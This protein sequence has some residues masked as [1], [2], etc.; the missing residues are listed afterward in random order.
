[1]ASK[2]NVSKSSNIQQAAA[3]RARADSMSAKERK[4]LATK[5]AHARWKRD[6]DGISVAT[7]EGS[8]QLPGFDLPCAVLKDGRRIFSER[9]LA[10]AFTHVR[11]GS[12]FK[13]RRQQPD[14]EQLPVFMSETV[15]SYL[16]E[17]ARERLATPIRYR[18]AGGGI[19]ARGVDAELLADLCDAYL[20]A[21]EDGALTSPV[22][23]RKAAAAERLTR[24][25]AKVG[26]TALID[27]ATGYQL[28]RDK[29]EL[30][31]L[32]DVY[33]REE[34]RP[35][36]AMFPTEF[37]RQ[38]F[39]LRGLTT[40]DVRKRPAYFGHLTNGVVYD[41]LLPGMVEKLNQV[42]P[43][44]EDGRR[45]RRHHQ[46]ATNEGVQHL[47]EHLSGVLFLMKASKNWDDFL[48]RLDMAAPKQGG[49][50]D[51]VDG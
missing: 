4:S 26:V 50:D 7:H 17:A 5:A 33:V 44:N 16:S 21:R 39:R 12:E 15:S 10:A 37:Y 11:S 23:L 45:R 22:M 40:D 38:I 25:L 24:A 42:N 36:T 49:I 13:K 31:R 28:E 19:P 51:V 46:H 41:R 18:H 2:K 35:W 27:E 8:V 32:L 47:R 1:M 6:P 34:F 48:Q 30:Q 14:E 9:G 3:G 20:A 43:T 29:G